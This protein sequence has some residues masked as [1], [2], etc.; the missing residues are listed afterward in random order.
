VK[1]RSL[2]VYVNDHAESGLDRFDSPIAHFAA[3]LGIVKD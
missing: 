3:V 1:S 2:H